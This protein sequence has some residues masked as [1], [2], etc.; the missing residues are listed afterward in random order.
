[1]PNLLLFIDD[2]DVFQR[3]LS[4]ACR[5]LPDITPP[6]FAS[7]GAEALELIKEGLRTSAPLPNIVFVDVNMPVM[8]GFDFLA[9][10][11]KLRDDHP[12]VDSIRPVVMLSSSNDDR[13]RQKA[14][15]LGADGYIV[16]GM[17]VAA[18]T[19][20]IVTALTEQTQ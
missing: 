14:A 11:A 19:E 12:R 16:K 2:D 4:R 13:D 1:M 17:T 10:L 18:L 9:G 7:D 8:N 6:V 5:D 3:I 20:S 15:S